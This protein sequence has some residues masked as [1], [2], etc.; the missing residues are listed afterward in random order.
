VLIT[1]LI[2]GYAWVDL[3]LHPALL[4]EEQ[5]SMKPDWS[6]L[7]DLMHWGGRLLRH[8]AAPLLLGNAVVL[9]GMAALV[10]RALTR[11]V[12]R[13]RSPQ[14][15]AGGMDR[16]SIVPGSPPISLRPPSQFRLAPPGSPAGD[17]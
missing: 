6:Q 16:V 12:R 11:W 1:L 14:A 17:D 5:I 15:G 7:P 8:G 10:G 2:L 4:A 9:G 3:E 13:L